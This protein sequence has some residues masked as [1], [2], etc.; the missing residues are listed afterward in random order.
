MTS[1]PRLLRF[2]LVGTGFWARATHAP[3]LAATQGVEFAA[4]WGRDRQATAELAA[5]YQVVPQAYLWGPAGQSAAPLLV[6][7]VTQLRTALAELAADAR[8]GQTSHPC[9]V[10]FG[11]DVGRVLAQAQRQ[12]DAAR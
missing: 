5:A 8:S 3:A 9:D 6:D 2:G 7:P 1:P 11:R 10:R 4:V 12:M